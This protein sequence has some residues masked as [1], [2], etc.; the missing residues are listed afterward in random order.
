[1]RK[2]VARLR[3]DERASHQHHRPVISYV[4]ITPSASIERG[5]W[6][7]GRTSR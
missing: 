2:G 3:V 7:C 4:L 5:A 1:L 6:W